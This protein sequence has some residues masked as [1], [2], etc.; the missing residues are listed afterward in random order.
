[1]Y[2]QQA[3]L[4]LNET[5]TIA[6]TYATYFS[7]NANPNSQYGLSDR[8][9]ELTT[10][11]YNIGASGVYNPQVSQADSNVGLASYTD[12][13]AAAGGYVIY[14]NKSNTNM[15]Q[16]V[17]SKTSVAFSPSL[18][19]F[20]SLPK[21]NKVGMGKKSDRKVYD[22]TQEA[23]EKSRNCLSRLPYPNGRG[24]SAAIY[25]PRLRL[26]YGNREDTEYGRFH[27]CD[28]GN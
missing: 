23:M 16:S 11:G 8:Q 22:E 5:L 20:P 25:A 10:A 7:S 17:Y 19:E 15:M 21:L 28:Y 3:G 13:T 27:F 1:M 26:Y 12:S 4:T 9:Q 2:S 24:V 6:G 14:P 18:L